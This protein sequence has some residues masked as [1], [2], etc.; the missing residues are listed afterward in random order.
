MAPWLKAAPAWC[1]SDHRL[2]DGDF[3]KVGFKQS[4]TA[5]KRLFLFFNVL[6]DGPPFFHNVPAF[7]CGVGVRE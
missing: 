7:F 3:K 2:F 1:L 6:N 5:R 4:P